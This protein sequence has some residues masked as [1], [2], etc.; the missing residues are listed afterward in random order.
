[1]R[2]RLV[3]PLVVLGLLLGL[4]V[5]S[6]AAPAFEKPSIGSNDGEPTMTR[7]Q[8]LSTLVQ[9][10]AMLG[11]EATLSEGLSKMLD[12]Y[13]ALEA[14]D[15]AE[16]RGV[17]EL[18]S[19]LVKVL[20]TVEFMDEAAALRSRG[21]YVDHPLSVMPSTW[22]ASQQS[23]GITMETAEAEVERAFGLLE[24]GKIEGLTLLLQVY[25]VLERELGAE[26]EASILVRS[27]LVGMLEVGGFAE[28]ATN[29]RARG[30]VTPASEEDI[31]AYA[32]VWLLIIGAEN[33]ADSTF[34]TGDAFAKPNS[35]SSSSS[36]S[37]FESSSSDSSSE[38]S[39]ESSTDSSSDSSD[40]SWEDDEEYKPKVFQP[41]SV[42]PSLGL[43][44]GLGTW[45]PE[46][47][48][49][50]FIWLLGLDVH[51]TLF[52]ARFFN[53]QLGGGG[54][55]G[56]N[57]DKRWLADAHGEV[58]L[59][60][61][62]S[63][64]YLRPEFGGGYDQ[65]AGGDEPTTTSFAVIA[66]PY[67]HFGGTLGVR[68]G[69]RFGLYGRAVRLNRDNALLRNETRVRAGFLLDNDG[70]FALDFAFVFTDYEAPEGGAGARLFAGALGV[71]I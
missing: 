55:F 26:E 58:I 2:S 13:I 7:D 53:M 17:K 45:Q 9:G 65:V 49:K 69:D 71:R 61:D 24:Q 31:E 62:F 10:E 32:Q 4:P 11:D 15:G 41:G 20:E 43:D 68:F 57:R 64:L 5:T 66:A 16:A 54:V 34:G 36:S 35:N 60:F 25:E 28:E 29:L 14:I 47:G 46:F 18:R 67:Y 44:L 22:F 1:M 42:V 8:A 33:S 3:A 50:G 40:E 12:A 6:H 51:W 59:G 48:R 70:E 19:W 39:S 21:S 52:S 23:S 37:P 56:R 30:S 27:F 38:S 63:K